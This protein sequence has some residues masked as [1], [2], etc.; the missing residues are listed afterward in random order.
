MRFPFEIEKEY[1][2]RLAKE[3]RKKGEN[4]GQGLEVSMKQVGLHCLI[5]NSIK[6]CLK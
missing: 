3:S 4:R 2:Y 1:K 6:R 5:L